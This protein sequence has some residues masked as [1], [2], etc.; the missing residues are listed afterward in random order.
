MINISLVQTLHKAI[1]IDIDTENLDHWLENIV[2]LDNGKTLFTGSVPRSVFTHLISAGENQRHK[3][4]VSYQIS[5]TVQKTSTSSDYRWFWNDKFLVSSAENMTIEADGRIHQTDNAK[6]GTITASRIFGNDSVEQWNRGATL[7]FTAIKGGGVINNQNDTSAGEKANDNIVFRFEKRGSNHKSV[8]IR[9]QVGRYMSIRETSVASGMCYNGGS[10]F[11]EPAEAVFNLQVQF[12][13]NNQSLYVKAPN[14]SKSPYW[15]S[16]QVS[17]S[18]SVNMTAAQMFQIVLRNGA[19]LRPNLDPRITT[20]YWTEREIQAGV[21]SEE[22]VISIG[23]ELVGDLGYILNS[24][25]YGVAFEQFEPTG[26]L[27]AGKYNVTTNMQFINVEGLEFPLIY[28]NDNQKTPRVDFSI[29]TTKSQNAERIKRV[30]KDKIVYVKMPTAWKRK[31]VSG[32]Y[33]F[34]AYSYNQLDVEGNRFIFEI[35]DASQIQ[36]IDIPLLVWN[37]EEVK[38]TTQTYVQVLLENSNYRQLQR[39]Y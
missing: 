26:V 14:Q 12:Y 37:Y 3:I 6:E 21:Y 34:T 31:L 1:Q 20:G 2:I 35:T 9:S 25:G 11:I 7:P 16:K 22:K 4:A 23:Q 19:W 28:V 27:D 18:A 29:Y 33:G 30:L 13:I 10:I 36:Q 24:K 38:D 8:G 17:F 15:Q 39:G 32:F 5:K